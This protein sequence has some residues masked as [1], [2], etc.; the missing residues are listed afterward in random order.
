MREECAHRQWCNSLHLSNH[1]SNLHP[2]CQ[3]RLVVWSQ[4]STHS[5]QQNQIQYNG[6]SVYDNPFDTDVTLS[7]K[8]LDFTILLLILGTN[9]H[10]NSRTPT[11][12]ELDTCPHIH[13]T[14]EAEWN[15]Q[16]LCLV[17][18]QSVEV[19]VITSETGTDVEPG[20]F[21]ISSVYSF[22]A[23]A[24]T[25]HQLYDYN[26]EWSISMIQ[27][28][29]PGSRTF[30]SKEWHSAVTP[31]QLSER[32]SIGLAQSK[33]T[34]WVTTQWGICSAILPLSWWYQTD[35]MYHQCKLRGQWFYT[36]TMIGKY[37]SLTNNTCAQLFANESF[38]A[39]AY[40]MEKKSMASAALRQFIHNFSVPEQ[41][42]FD[43]SVEQ[44]K[45][46]TD[47]M[48]HIR[49]FGIDY[50]I[51]EPY[52]PQQN[53]AETVIH[54]VKKHWFHQMVKR[55][56]LKQLWDYGIVWACEFMSLMSN[57]S[58][59]L[60]GRT[61]M[62]Q[63]AWETPD[64]SE[65]L[66]FGFYDWVWCKDNAGLGE[67]CVGCWLGVAH[68]VGNLMSYWI[69]TE[70]SWVIARDV[71]SIHILNNANHIIP[72]GDDVMLQDWN[73]YPLDTDP[74]FID[75]F[76]NVVSDDTVPEQ[77]ESFTPDTFDNTYLHMEVALPRGRAEDPQFAKVTKWLCDKDGCPIGMANDNPMLDTQEYEV[78]FLDG[79]CEANVIVQHIFSQVDEEGN[80]HIY[81]TT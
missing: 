46:K 57:S 41:L 72:H 16:T 39:K 66:D 78:E 60:E 21:Q 9:I 31:E 26:S 6:V 14:L 40:P 17:V 8:H 65:Y 50:H 63:L 58:F 23:M 3:W 79:H 62:E 13:L 19:E 64:I 54:E 20:L 53:Q 34:L 74:D 51:T 29:V 1:W 43:G 77:D 22:Q 18:I 73:D 69:L 28:K 45:P 70:A 47:F 27:T 38:F 32:W 33:Q 30:I 42:T 81:L 68:R 37:K 48:K 2:C 5:T 61:P 11:Q 7:I 36:D 71:N 52:W 35:C 80:Q 55:N 25:L 10:F 24:E 67:N 4:I 76:Y 44:V 59:N 49:D 12:H 56:V 75:E 15:P